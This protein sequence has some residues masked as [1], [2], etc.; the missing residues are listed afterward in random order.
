LVSNRQI[1][2]QVS[3]VTVPSRAPAIADQRAE[4]DQV[5]SA[6]DWWVSTDA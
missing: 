2:S 4:T 3:W 6:T 5:A 1:V